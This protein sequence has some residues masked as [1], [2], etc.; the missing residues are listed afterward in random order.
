M[1]KTPEE[2]SALR[3]MLRFAQKAQVVIDWFGIEKE[4]IDDLLQGCDNLLDV[5]Q[6]NE[7]F[8]DRG[9]IAHR[10][11]NMPLALD[12]LKAAREG[13]WEDA[14]QTLILV[15]NPET[16]RLHLL[17]L[18]RLRC[19]AR[20]RRLALLALD[21][22]DA[23]RFHACVP[24][25]LALLDGMGQELTGQGFLRQG[26]RF[27]KTESFLEIGPGV[28]ALVK[29]MTESRGRVNTDELD[30]PYRHGI[31][32]GTDLTYDTELVAAK[33]WGALLAVGSHATDL[34]IPRPPET[35]PK[36]LLA[37]LR[38]YA[39]TQARID[40]IKRHCDA[41]Q[42]RDTTTI[43]EEAKKGIVEQDTPEGAALQ[44]MEA[45]QSGNFGAMASL[46]VDS[47]RESMNAVAGRTRANV[48]E[49]PE[50]FRLSQVED[51]A[52]AAAWVTVNA[53]WPD[54]HHEFIRL[55][56]LYFAEGECRPRTMG[57]GK[58]LIHSFWPLE[59]ASLRIAA[60]HANR[61]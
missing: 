37:A 52:P 23:G 45:W 5:Q 3:T 20:R 10:W 19:F 47:L 36:G 25:V 8:A 29:K 48:G 32:H 60:I 15:Y 4:T 18:S 16:I 49:P 7:V 58:W 34:E 39:A 27:A 14:D 33:A 31:L 1:F 50:S 59:A 42:P 2:L 55:R 22:Y 53:D 41:W 61:G 40:E 38:D 44:L 13:R 26:V 24:V 35:P 46:S 17:Q 12:A 6:F 21:D 28:T 30:V 51:E 54:D 56:L 57:S 11:L 9:W 43:V